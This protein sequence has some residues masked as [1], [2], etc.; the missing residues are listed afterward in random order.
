MCVNVCG[1]GWL[2]SAKLNAAQHS[3]DIRETSVHS[4]DYRSQCDYYSV[5]QLS[6]QGM[7]GIESN[8]KHYPYRHIRTHSACVY[9]TAYADRMK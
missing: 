7:T 9:M 1:G 4:R 3:G 2:S 6:I 8:M 5:R